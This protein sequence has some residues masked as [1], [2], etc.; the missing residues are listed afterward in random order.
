MLSAHNIAYC[1]NSVKGGAKK[2][3][4]LISF[5]YPR[6]KALRAWALRFFR[7]F[8]L[9][10]GRMYHTANQPHRKSDRNRMH[11]RRRPP[12]VAGVP[13]TGSAAFRLQGLPERAACRGVTH[14]SCPPPEQRVG[15]PAPAAPETQAASGVSVRSAFNA[16][17]VGFPQGG[18]PAGRA[19]ASPWHAYR[20]QTGICSRGLRASPTDGTFRTGLAGMPI[21]QN[22]FALPEH[23]VFA[24]SG[25]AR[26]VRA[27][28]LRLQARQQRRLIRPILGA[29]APLIASVASEAAAA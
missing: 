13:W 23:W 2:S 14:G 28:A 12:Q 6:H 10:D 19:G 11:R 16:Y 26:T 17:R 1:R 4:K 7:A 29:A 8:S 5:A 21:E 24:A 22:L 20:L 27:A 18:Q 3:R 9:P 15:Q 25:P